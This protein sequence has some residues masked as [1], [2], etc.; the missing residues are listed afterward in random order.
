MPSSDCA[1]ASSAVRPP[2]VLTLMLVRHA[3]TWDQQA[4]TR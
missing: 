3:A 2:A 1:R 4:M